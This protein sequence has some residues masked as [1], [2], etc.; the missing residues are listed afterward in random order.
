MGIRKSVFVYKNQ[1]FSIHKI[2]PQKILNT[3]NVRAILY[4]VINIDNH[5]LIEEKDEFEKAAITVNY[6]DAYLCSINNT[7][8]RI[9]VWKYWL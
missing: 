5:N 4:V 1:I 6:R 8:T 7:C 3:V 2:Y 9:S